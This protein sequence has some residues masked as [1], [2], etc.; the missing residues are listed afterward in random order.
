MKR[1]ANIPRQLQALFQNRRLLWQMIKQD[2]KNRYLGSYLGML[3]AFVQPTVTILIFWFVF[4]VGFKAV[5]VEGVPFILWLVAGIIPWFFM[6]DAVSNATTCILESP[7]LVKKV[8]FRV[9][10]LPLVKVGSAMLVHSFFLLLMLALFT[11]YGVAPTVY[12]LQ[13]PYYVLA[14]LVLTLGLSWLTSSLVLFLRDI[15]QLVGMV[16]QF[17]F[18]MT[19]IFW[20]L[21]MV[22]ESYHFILKL[23]PAYYIIEGYR[24]TMIYHIWF[25]EDGLLSVYYWAVALAVL[26][27][28]MEVFRRLRPHFADVL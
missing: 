4:E 16:L 8:V 6:A 21:S 25:W 12:Y 28:G 17:G 5:P 1:I 13:L 14:S 24:N 2:G 7:F 18:W 11:G 23:N 26:F 9:E 20:S 22:P 10:L 3:W 15:G 27:A 19:P